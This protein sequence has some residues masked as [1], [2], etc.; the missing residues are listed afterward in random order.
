MP[1]M[2]SLRIYETRFKS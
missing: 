1:T 2:I